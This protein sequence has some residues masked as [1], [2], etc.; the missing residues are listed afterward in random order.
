MLA[1]R[2]TRAIHVL[3][4]SAAELWDVW[5]NADGSEAE[6]ALIAHLTRTVD[7]D[8][9]EARRC[10]AGL[11][12]DWRAAG[13]CDVAPAPRPAPAHPNPDPCAAEE[14]VRLGDGCRTVTMAGRS[15]AIDVEDEVLRRHIAE[16]LPL[17]DDPAHAGPSSVVRL[18]GRASDWTL[19]VQGG[20]TSPSRG[21]DGDEAA[22]ST[23]HTLIELACRSQDLLLKIHGAGLRAPDGAGV[24]LVAPGGSGKTTLAA[25][26]NA[27]GWDLLS[28]DVVPVDD[29]GRLLGLGAPICVKAGGW[30]IL[31]TLRPSLARRPEV[32]RFG[33][34]IRYLAPKGTC[35]REPLTPAVLLFP[36]WRPGEPAATRM[37]PPEEAL[38]R[39]VE[40]EA[41]IGELTSEKLNKLASWIGA[42]PAH[43]VEYPDLRQG[44]AMAR[45]L[46]REARR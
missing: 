42:L 29:Q 4:A 24:L 19:S 21:G 37:A 8:P 2:G 40:A 38:R 43:V 7:L 9:G 41:V 18:L 46:A 15:F 12:A 10:V 26:L 44:L 25:A 28:D 6:S 23:L 22:V 11:M 45:R 32:L 31:T 1:R 30:P 14:T 20:T 39:V 13:L 27:E 34:P 3:N 17:P 36:R 35:P 33:E 5:I 16:R